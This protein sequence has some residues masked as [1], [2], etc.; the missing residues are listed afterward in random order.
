ML[1]SVIIICYNQKDFIAQAIESV[2]SQQTGFTYELI[3]G[4]DSSSDGT[5][6]IISEYEK[7][8]S[9]IRYYRHKNNLG[10]M[11]N[12]SFCHRQA[13][14]KYLAVL[15][16]DDYWID[17]EKL[18]KQ[19]KLM[20]SNSNIGMVHTQYDVLY[21]YP[22]LFGKR[23]FKSVLSDR[24]ANENCS[25]SGIYSNSMICSST[26]CYRKSII[27][28]SKLMDEFDKGT[29]AMEDG[30]VHLMCSLN[31]EVVFI[32]DSSTVYRVNQ[33]SVSHFTSKQKRL[34]FLEDTLNVRRY[35]EKL[36]VIDQETKENLYQNRCLSFAHHY[37]KSNN[38]KEFKVMYKQINHK[39]LTLR[40]MYLGM[41]LKN[42]KLIRDESFLK[43]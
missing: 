15:D 21:M 29:F 27:D 37:Y 16:G 19:V 25:F 43:H 1:L 9:F 4:D 18:E 42:N 33:S 3:I 32:K 17:N 2:L 10:L 41:W 28:D 34:Q 12:Y 30:P 23:Y 38:P 39:P 40:L 35:F 36:T 24:V 20:E 5:S 26:V 6:E 11:G 22:K 7:K 8:H 14:G 13:K 31:H